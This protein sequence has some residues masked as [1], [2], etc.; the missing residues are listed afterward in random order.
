MPTVPTST[1]S[2][3]AAARTG[4]GTRT[5]AHQRLTGAAC[6][7]CAGPDGDRPAPG[8]G[9]PTTDSGDVSLTPAPTPAPTGA[10]SA[11]GGPKASAG[12]PDH[13]GG[14]NGRL[15]TSAGRSARSSGVPSA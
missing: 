3:A 12:A 10:G 13:A 8:G 14:R 4:T 6:E 9:E 15:P 5:V 1:T 2:A 7:A 11:G